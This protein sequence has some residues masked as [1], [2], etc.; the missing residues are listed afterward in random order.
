M[1]NQSN[2]EGNGP[3]VRG[4]QDMNNRLQDPRLEKYC[5]GGHC[6]FSVESGQM[7]NQDLAV[8]LGRFSSKFL[9]ERFLLLQLAGLTFAASATFDERR[10]TAS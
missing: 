10:S 2:K 9:C 8:K 1:R 4:T 6:C 5:S 7:R 3:D